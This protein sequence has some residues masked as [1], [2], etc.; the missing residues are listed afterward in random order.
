MRQSSD[1]TSYHL[2]VIPRLDRGIS[3]EKGSAQ[4]GNVFV[5]ILLGVFLFGSL[6]YMFS[7]NAQQGTGNLTKQQANIAAQEILNYARL[8]EGAVDRVRRNGCSETE[9]S[10]ANDVVPGYEHTPPA[11]D[12]CKVFDDAGGKVSW[13]NEQQSWISDP[14]LSGHPLF[15]EIFI[16]GK[17]RIPRVGSTCICKGNANEINLYFPWLKK[18]VCTE[19]NKLTNVD[20]PSG[21]PPVDPDGFIMST[22]KFDGDFISNNTVDGIDG[23]TS[24]CV[25][26]ATGFAPN[27][28]IFVHVLLAR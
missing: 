26:K 19:L 15:G 23:Q 16:S 5:I 14:L 9:I 6:M 13:E 2:P 17:S 11:R 27:S 24:A 4:A 20:N 21:N 3:L 7:R 25:Q 8:V 18:E 12:E 1:I 28:Y 10:F 22:Q